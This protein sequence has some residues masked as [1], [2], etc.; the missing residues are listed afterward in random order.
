MN[1][2]MVDFCASFS[3]FAWAPQ[4]GQVTRRCFVWREGGGGGEGKIA[5][6]QIKFA[7]SFSLS[8]I[9]YL[10]LYLLSCIKTV[11]TY[12][13]PNSI[14]TNEGTHITYLHYFINCIIAL[15]KYFIYS[16][17]ICMYQKSPQDHLGGPHWH[18]VV[19]IL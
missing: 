10:Y 16:V 4:Q 18:I 19:W 6:P 11:F 14:D 12:L 5:K 17:V 7:K 8:D 9:C 13:H 1:A 15:F 3:V 2:T